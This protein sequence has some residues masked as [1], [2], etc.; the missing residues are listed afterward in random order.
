[1]K[2]TKILFIILITYI[3][4][5]SNDILHYY[6][7]V[8][9][10]NINIEIGSVFV[11]TNDFINRLDDSS[12]LELSN[13]LNDAKRLIDNFKFFEAIALCNELE[14]IY[15]DYY[16]LYY[17]RGLA[18][19]KTGDIYYSTLDFNKLLTM[20]FNDKEIYEIVGGFFD[21]INDYESTIKTYLIAYKIHNETYWLFLAGKTSLKYNDIKSA[22]S[23]FTYCLKVGSGYGFEGFADINLLQNQYT[24]ALNNYSNAYKSYSSY[25]NNQTDMQRLNSKISNVIVQSELYNWNYNLENREFEKATNILNNLSAYSKDFPEINLALAKTHF[26]IGNYQLSKNMLNR[27]IYEN[28][29]FDEAYAILAQIYL[30]ENNERNAIKILEKGLEYSYN[31][32]RLYETLANM[33]Y[34]AGYYY[35]PNKIISQIIDIYNISDKN[36]IEYSKYLISK[37]EYYKARELLRQI[38][39]YKST[40]DEI[41]ELIGFN[42]ILDKAESLNENGYYVDIMELLSGYKFK[43]YEEQLRIGYIANTYYKLGSI[44]KAI[45]ILKELF[46]ANSISINNVV[47]LRDLLKIRISN[48]NYAQTQKDKDMAYIQST[49]FWEEDLNSNTQLITDKIYDFIKNNKYDEALAY[50]EQL[51][52]KNYD[53]D[54]IKKI[55][56]IVYGYYATFLYD[57]RQFDKAKSVSNLAIR[58]NKDNYDAIAIKNQVYVDIYLNSVGNYNNIDAYVKLSD[59]RKEILNISPAYIENMIKLAEAL[60]YEYNIEGYDIIN[61]IFKYIDINGARDSLLGRIYN[62]SR[63]YNYSANA[64]GRASKY[65]GVDLLNRIESVIKID[66]YNISSINFNQKR[67]ARDFYALSKLYVKIN[68]YREAMNSIQYAILN[69]NL[70]LDYRYQLGIINEKIGNTK[71]ALDYYEYVIKN[72][73]NHAAANYRAAIIYLDYMRNYKLAYDYVLN[74]ISLLPNDYSGYELLGKI[75]KNRAESLLENNIENLLNNSLVSYK[76]ASDKAIWGKDKDAKKNIEIEIQNILNKLLK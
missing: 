62:K 12:K 14:P 71:E 42:I 72:N 10:R 56:S 23:Y 25:G 37:K 5:Y 51:K 8:N 44:D 59:I 52:I 46:D 22:N 58:R 13:K 57:N 45:N 27:F 26:R 7:K 35:Y 20:Y 16:M 63:L 6:S 36:K 38:N 4:A 9:D 3:S 15:R 2:L 39:Y 74:Y 76:T 61:N 33:L 54:Y 17:I 73:K 43:G 24:D 50:I 53:I 75:Y 1:M 34:N 32:P 40:A 28:K 47:L 18:Y 65:I 49:I 67:K 31:K 64:Y 48:N 70:N 21:S 66:N 41:V 19:Y 69:D 11:K 30:Y 60:V 55:E 29:T 68:N